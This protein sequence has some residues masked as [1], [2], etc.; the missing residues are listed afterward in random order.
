MA[1]PLILELTVILNANRKEIEDPEEWP[2]VDLIE[3]LP[4]LEVYGYGIRELHPQP[5]K[6]H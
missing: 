5:D 6:V 1:K 4:G 3:T 2:I